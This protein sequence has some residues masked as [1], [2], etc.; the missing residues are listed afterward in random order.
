[1]YRLDEG[2]WEPIPFDGQAPRGRELTI[3]ALA[4]DPAAGGDV[5]LVTDDRLFQSDSDGWRV[6]RRPGNSRIL[7]AEVGPGG[8]V[9][10][11]LDSG[12]R[13]YSELARYDGGEWTVYAVD[14]YGLPAMGDLYQ[15]AEGWFE[16]ALDGSVWFN[17]ITEAIALSDTECDG[18]AS[19]DGE[20]LTRHLRD[21]C[22]YA[23][24]VA[25]DGNVWL[26]GGEWFVGRS[27][28]PGPVSTYVITTEAV[29]GAE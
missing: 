5:W 23:M 4:V 9:W 29:A 19:F 28:G 25:P 13:L 8:T 18:V 26:Q 21:T 22:I 3:D 1:M 16:V 20:K 10:A 15:G 7:R 11:W 17:P 2:G 6:I 24:E 14:S 12:G 27:L